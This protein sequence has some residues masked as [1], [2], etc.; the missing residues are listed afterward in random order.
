LRVEVAGRAGGARAAVRGELNLASAPALERVLIE[1]AGIARP[2]LLDLRELAFIDASGLGVLLR[3]AARARH[4]GIEFDLVAG[5]CVWRLLELC[6]LT[7][8]FGYL[9]SQPD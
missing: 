1:Q 6:G 3:T 2:V 4:D 7:T 9:D 8:Q 5:H